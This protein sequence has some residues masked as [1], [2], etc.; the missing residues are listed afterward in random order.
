MQ[1][2]RMDAAQ[3]RFCFGSGYKMLSISQIERCG[4]LSKTQKNERKYETIIKEGN[5]DL[6]QIWR[7]IAKRMKRGENHG[8]R[9]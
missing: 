6:T 2:P 1:K 3:A 8:K 7:E 9:Y 5:P 4:R